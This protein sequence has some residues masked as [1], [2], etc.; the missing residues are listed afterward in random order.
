[1]VASIMVR[2]L[3]SSWL[4]IS[5]FFHVFDADLFGGRISHRSPELVH[6]ILSSIHAYQNR[7]KFSTV[8]ERRVHAMHKVVQ[9]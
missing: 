4:F 9:G 2:E 6:I 3:S 5:S 8:V 1:M 7:L